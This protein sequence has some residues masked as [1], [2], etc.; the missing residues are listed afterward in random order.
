[1]VPADMTNIQCYS[2]AFNSLDELKGRECLDPVNK[3]ELFDVPCS[4]FCSVSI[5]GS[6][7]FQI[8]FQILLTLQKIIIRKS[9]VF[10]LSRS[11]SIYC[12][13]N[14]T[15]EEEVHCCKENLCN[16]VHRLSSTSYVPICILLIHA[17]N[18]LLF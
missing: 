17:F 4:G 13:N 10:I 8:S 16:F 6:F 18:Y 11:C 2:C 12:T 1:M 15:K 3:D 7:F 9:D 5:R 14:S